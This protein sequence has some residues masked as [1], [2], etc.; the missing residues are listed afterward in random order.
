MTT[1]KRRFAKV[2]TQLGGDSI[3]MPVNIVYYCQIDSFCM[4]IDELEAQ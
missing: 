2:V 3:P 4:L 1:A